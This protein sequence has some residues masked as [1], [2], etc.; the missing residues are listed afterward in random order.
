MSLFHTENIDE[1]NVVEAL[2]ELNQAFID[3]HKTIQTLQKELAERDE[4]LLKK[5]D[6]GFNETNMRL[7]NLEGRVE[8]LEEKV[9]AGFKNLSSEMQQ[10]REETVELLKVIAQNTAK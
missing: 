4:R 9:D 10:T 6:S 7:E 1:T 8:S 2:K 3:D 5:I